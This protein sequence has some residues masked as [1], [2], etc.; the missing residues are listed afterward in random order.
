VTT[1]SVDG[2]G[3]GKPGRL[4]R[5]VLW[6]QFAGSEW[7]LPTDVHVAER[8]LLGWRCQSAPTDGE[9]PPAVASLLATA[10]RK[11]ATLTF[12]S[13]VRPPAG[14]TWK[15]GRN[16]VWIT[17][18]TDRE[19]AQGIFDADFFSWNQQGQ[20]VV[21]GSPGVALALDE[22]YLEL[23]SDP[24]LFEE[25]KSAGAQGVLLPGVDGSV[26]G[27]YFFNTGISSAVG[28]ELDSATHAMGGRCVVTRGEDFRA[29]L[30][31]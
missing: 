23:H 1:N 11:H 20:V 27:L 12:A 26:A 2:G 24:A 28:R 14:A 29:Q 31:G 15:L 5:L 16:F 21:L 4:D 19:A 22:R 10:L 13:P 9:P 6:P 8:L 17:S 25:L 3:A 30:R 18:S 7:Q